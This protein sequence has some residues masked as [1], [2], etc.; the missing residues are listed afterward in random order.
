MK[1]GSP[2]LYA[3]K[4]LRKPVAKGGAGWGFKKALRMTYGDDFGK[5]VR[6]IPGRKK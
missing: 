1:Q 5:A 3:F 4:T 6:R 2:S